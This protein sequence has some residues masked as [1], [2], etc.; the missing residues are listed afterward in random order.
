MPTPETIEVEFD[1]AS[2]PR[3]TQEY[4]EVIALCKTSLSYRCGVFVRGNDPLWR[5]ILVRQAKEWA[6]S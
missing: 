3:W 2:L 1:P 5:K 4:P 6:D